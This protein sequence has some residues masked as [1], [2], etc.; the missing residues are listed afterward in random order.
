M[1]CPLRAFEW[2]LLA[3]GLIAA[4]VADVR[5]RRVPNWLTIALLALGLTART[6]AGGLD[7]LA[8]GLLG[9]ALGTAL[10]IVPF[11]RGWLGGGDVK[12]LGAIG[13]WLGP[14]FIVWS[15]LYGTAAGGVLSVVYVLGFVPREV[16]QDVMANFKAMLLLRRVEA[17]PVREARY[18]PP[19]ALALGVGAVITVMTHAAQLLAH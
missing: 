14:E 19:Y 17:P 8:G 16:R 6:L 18:S 3:L 1:T 7:A 5:S 2:I 10:L 13:A 12:L 15:A 11:A 9:T 4:S